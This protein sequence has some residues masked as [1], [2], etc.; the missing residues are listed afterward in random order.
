[1]LNFLRNNRGI[2]F[3]LLGSLVMQGL[4]FLFAYFDN[5]IPSWE[6]GCSAA[7]LVFYIAFA[8]LYF[9]VLRRIFLWLKK[10]LK[11]WSTMALSV[12]YGMLMYGWLVFGLYLTLLFYIVGSDTLFEHYVK[13]IKLPR[14]GQEVYLYESS[15]M[16]EMTDVYIRRDRRPLKTKIATMVGAPGDV[17]ITEQDSIISITGFKDV[18]EYNRYS[19]ELRAREK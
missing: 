18:Y 7:C 14:S 9:I 17:I 11:M 2:L 8:V 3:L 4:I 19:K 1:M 13:S 6:I 5:L 15:F 10:G 12:L 16:I